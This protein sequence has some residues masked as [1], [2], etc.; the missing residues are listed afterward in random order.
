MPTEGETGR[1]LAA[2]HPVSTASDD[3]ARTLHVDAR[4]AR[5]SDAVPAAAVNA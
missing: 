1:L 3:T 4:R 2:R 5:D